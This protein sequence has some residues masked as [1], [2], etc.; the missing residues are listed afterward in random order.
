MTISKIESSH[1]IL[2]YITSF[3]ETA[4]HPRIMKLIGAVAY[5][6]AW[7]IDS[8]LQAAG[9]IIQA[10]LATRS[11]Q[12]FT[13]STRALVERSLGNNIAPANLRDRVVK[14]AIPWGRA[15]DTE[16]CAAID[17]ARLV[18]AHEQ[19]NSSTLTRVV[20]KVRNIV[21]SLFSFALGYGITP[22]R[23][24][25]TKPLRK[26]CSTL[27]THPEWPKELLQNAHDRMLSSSIAPASPVQHKEKPPLPAP[28]T[29]ISLFKGETNETRSDIL[30]LVCNSTEYQLSERLKTRMQQAVYA[31]NNKMRAN[32][33]ALQQLV[34]L[35]DGLKEQEKNALTPS[36]FCTCTEEERMHL[37]QIVHDHALLSTRERL[38][39]FQQNITDY[40][41]RNFAELVVKKFN[42][43]PI[44]HKMKM[45]LEHK[46][47]AVEKIAAKRIENVPIEPVATCQW[48]QT[49]LKTLA[50]ATDLLLLV[51]I[52][53]ELPT[54]I[55]NSIRV[56][57]SLYY[58][59]NAAH[60]FLESKPP[61][62]I[63]QTAISVDMPVDMALK[64]LQDKSVA[65]LH[66]S[67]T[68]QK[69]QV[70]RV[71]AAAQ[72]A[73]LALRVFT[74]TFLLLP[75]A[76]RMTIPPAL[77]EMAA[78]STKTRVEIAASN[79]IPSPICIE[80][81]M[82]LA[83]EDQEDILF[84]VAHDEGYS[85][86]PFQT[87]TK[88]RHAAKMKEFAGVLAHYNK[89]PPMRRISLTPSKLRTSSREKIL[90]VLQLVKT[91][92]QDL[93]S[94]DLEKHIK[95]SAYPKKRSIA[96][97]ASSF[98]QL[99][100]HQRAL[101]LQPTSEE[102]ANMGHL[103]LKELITH[104]MGQPSEKEHTLRYGKIL[105]A[106]DA[107][108]PVDLDFLRLRFQAKTS[109]YSICC[110]ETLTT[111]AARIKVYNEKIVGHESRFQAL[112]RMGEAVDECAKLID[113]LH[114]ERATLIR[115]SKAL[116]ELL[117]EAKREK[118]AELETI[119]LPSEWLK[120]IDAGVCNGMSVAASKESLIKTKRVYVRQVLELEEQLAKSDS[121]AKK[122]ELRMKIAFIK[123][124]YYKIYDKA[125]SPPPSP[126]VAAND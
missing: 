27:W 120:Y 48:F 52:P 19:K 3:G 94:K 31:L 44:K 9:H 112:L 49:A 82:D 81:F 43:L 21:P 65:L 47:P 68:W 116:I 114:S 107:N 1:H 70:L 35:Y 10:G 105:Q 91:Y 30:F 104:I 40:A 78:Y 125:I 117:P 24:Y 123:A 60:R 73:A 32:T 2:S 85:D 72:G 14:A 6:A 59:S 119:P 45:F 83:E 115:E 12:S 80:D 108:E 84:Q 71:A 5:G 113:I 122:I 46:P 64:I 77:R 96:Q 26:A 38:Q 103:E 42:R 16:T 51:P 58:M 61:T 28:V 109:D 97:L 55:K 22:L 23:E 20:D 75:E 66:E 121:S 37:V 8:P 101:V 92:R 7:A 76:L 39:I 93:V 34:G 54:S 57:Q 11:M 87:Y 67:E 18:E 63:P 124:F 99:R 88:M 111:I 53:T 13:P 102:I 100:A 4:L 90:H 25:V 98:A 74:G 126:R 36:L 106:L 110:E 29:D 62:T 41:D 79:A 89:M 118:Y 15:I 95:E 33:A 50:T 86:T 69:K 56:L 17:A